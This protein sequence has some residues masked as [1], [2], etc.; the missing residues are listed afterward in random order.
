MWLGR[1][2]LAM[3]LQD[4]HVAGSGLLLAHQFSQCHR[5]Q[6]TEYVLVQARPQFVCHAATIVK[7]VFA[8]A[9][10]RRID[11]F[12]DRE[13]HVGDRYAVGRMREVVAATR[14]SNAFDQ[15]V[16]AQLAEQLLEIGQRYLL[17]F[18]NG[19]ERYWRV[20][21]VHRHVDHRRDGKTPFCRKPHL[22]TRHVA[23]AVG[24]VSAVHR[25]LSPRPDRPGSL[26]WLCPGQE[27]STIPERFSQLNSRLVHS[28]ILL[29]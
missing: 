10:L 14:T 15:P 27:D 1:L 21:A 8:A 17:S 20:R 7:A 29:I 18:G 12:V 22:C 24:S 11:R 13:D 4:R 2:R 19:R 23:E 16:P 3:I 26:A 28:T 9:A 25:H 6:I 5:T